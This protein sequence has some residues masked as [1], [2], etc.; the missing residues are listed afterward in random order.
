M[1]AY[2]FQQRF[3]PFVTDGS[4]PHT[5]R[6]RRKKG[7]AK[8]GDT[9]YL[10]YGLRTKWCKKIREEKCTKAKTI[11]I[12]EQNIYICSFRLSDGQVDEVK[13]ELLTGQSIDYLADPLSKKAANKLAWADGFRVDGKYLVL[14][15]NLI[16]MKKWW[17]QTHELPFIGDII[18]WKPKI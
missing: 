5:I 10:Y 3:V 1:P 9:L 15:T 17:K 13:E 18:Y 14:Y 6:A 4:K 8:K 16:L 11:I 7:F 12:T 2:N